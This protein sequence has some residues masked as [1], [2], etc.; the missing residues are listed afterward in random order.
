[1]DLFCSAVHALCLGHCV[2]LC[3][4]SRFAQCSCMFSVC[5][6][7]VFRLFLYVYRMCLCLQTV[8]R[9]CLCLQN[10]FRMCLYVNRMFSE[11]VCMFTD[12]FQTVSVCFR[13]IYTMFSECVCM[14]SVCFHYVTRP[15]CPSILDHICVEISGQYGCMSAFLKIWSNSFQKVQ[16]S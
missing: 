3:V 15:S 2:L 9:M 7:N 4:V 16:K 1:M 11:C 14:F 13:Y 8:F 6:H 5:L 12:C 10:V